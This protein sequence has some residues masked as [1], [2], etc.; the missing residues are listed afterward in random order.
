MAL[1]R[2]GHQVVI[3]NELHTRK[4][5]VVFVERIEGSA[6]GPEEKVLGGNEETYE[7]SNSV[8]KY[9]EQWVKLRGQDGEIEKIMIELLVKRHDRWIEN[10]ARSKT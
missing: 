3:G 7:G 8:S 2:Y 4:Y 1:E 10:G 6:T 9:T 5:Q